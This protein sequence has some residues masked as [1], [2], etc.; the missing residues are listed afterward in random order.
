MTVFGSIIAH[1][2]LWCQYRNRPT[3][4]KTQG[5]IMVGIVWVANALSIFGLYLY[6]QMSFYRFKDPMILNRLMWEWLQAFKLSFFLG[7]LLIFLLGY[8]FYRIRPVYQHIISETLS[9]S[10]EKQKTIAKGGFRYFIG[11]LL[12]VILLYAALIW[13]FIQWGFLEAFRLPTN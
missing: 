13:L 6:T 11:S 12:L 10:E 9:H 3:L 8:F 4:A 2:F 5:P 7:S 1:N